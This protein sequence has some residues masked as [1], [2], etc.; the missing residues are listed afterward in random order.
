MI[1]GSPTGRHAKEDINMGTM[2]VTIQLPGPNRITLALWKT[3][4][5]QKTPRKIPSPTRYL[6]TSAKMNI[7]YFSFLLMFQII[8]SVAITIQPCTNSFEDFPDIFPTMKN[9]ALRT[10]RLGMNCLIIFKIPNAVWK[11]RNI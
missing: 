7:F 5:S 2:S 1:L 10:L 6:F 9:L 11:A 3:T 4:A 8:K